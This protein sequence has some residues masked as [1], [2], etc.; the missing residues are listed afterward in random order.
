MPEV[1]EGDMRLRMTTTDW[2][3]NKPGIYLGLDEALYH[4]NKEAISSSLLRWPNT[5]A[6][7]HHELSSPQ[8]D[9]DSAALFLGSCIHQAFLEPTKPLPGIA[10]TCSV[11]T[12]ELPSLQS[13]SGL[14]VP[15][16]MVDGSVTVTLKTPPPD[17]LFIGICC[18]RPSV[19]PN[20]VADAAWRLPHVT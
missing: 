17:P 11:A 10:V 16:W 18:G 3:A 12:A 19:V 13:M 4:A 15:G 6:H 2:I 7:L 1:P 8:A 20:N 5:L 9:K 14:Y